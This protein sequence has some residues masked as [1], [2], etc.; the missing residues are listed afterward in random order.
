MLAIESHG[1]AEIE[2]LMERVRRPILESVG[3]G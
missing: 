3:E 1:F 2:P